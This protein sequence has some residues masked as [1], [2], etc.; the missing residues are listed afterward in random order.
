[1]TAHAERSLAELVEHV[2]AGFHR[3]TPQLFDDAEAELRSLGATAARAL[4][5]LA[6][7]RAQLI[8]HMAKEET[9]LF[10]WLVS[11]RAHTAGAPIRVMQLEHLD[12]LAYLD[13]VRAL[14]SAAFAGAASPHLD[15]LERSLRDHVRIEDEVL[16]PRA[17]VA[18]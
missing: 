14:A 17:L 5:A 4:E 7:L 13:R 16:F 6:D 10:P 1:M 18:R 15:A 8:S 12:T 11:E 9:V 2:V 3:P